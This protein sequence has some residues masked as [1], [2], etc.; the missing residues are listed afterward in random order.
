MIYRYIGLFFIGTCMVLLSMYSGV[1]GCGGNTGSSSIE[2]PE[3]CLEVQENAINETGER[4]ENG[5]YTLYVNSDEL[6]PWDAYCHDMRRSNPV[7]YLTVDESDNYSQIVTDDAVAETSYRRLRIDPVTLEIDPLDD[8]FATSDFDSFTPTFPTE[9]MGFIPAGWAEVQSFSFNN[10]EALANVSL[11]GTPFVFSEV[12][13]TNNLMDFFC[14]VD[15]EN[16]SEYYTTGTMAEVAA[17]LTSFSLTA[18]NTNSEMIQEGVSTRIVAD[19]D[20]LGTN[21]TFTTGSF[22]L[23]YG[24]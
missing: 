21:A 2:F 5:T 3:T 11:E 6:Q 8:T 4:P 15:S 20:N 22:P 19:C 7:E 9:S 14:Q 1:S 13:L 17:D 12:I 18:V 24:L 10:V 23:Q 16:A